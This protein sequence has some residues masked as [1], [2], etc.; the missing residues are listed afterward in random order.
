MPERPPDLL[1]AVD[2]RPPL[3]KLV[4]LGLQHAAL[5][6]IYLVFLVI[7]AQAAG[8]GSQMTVTVLSLGML[9]LA[10]GAV[11]QASLIGSGYLAVPVFSAIYLGPSIVAAKAGGLGL[12]F[13]MTIFAGAFEVALSRA[14]PWLRQLFPPAVSGFIVLVVGISIG[15]VGIRHVVELGDADPG[16]YLSHLAVAGLTGG[17][18][19]ALAVWGTG[20]LRLL[21]SMV[22]LVAGFVVALALG[23]VPKD[24]L[25]AIAAAPIVAVPVPGQAG[26]SFTLA[27]A[28]AFAAAALAATLRTI[29]VVTICQKLNDADWKRPDLPNIE[30]GVLADGLG[31]S[32]GGLV[33]GMGMCTASSLVGV[34]RAVRATS[35]RIAY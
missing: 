10:G 2:E 7:V 4:G 15:L 26:L 9:A 11:L 31:C 27:L 23:L 16:G 28:P 12:V 14:L 17:I 32:L 18:S 5:V 21:G 34:S 19:I 8:V 3:L 13:G 20:P 24:A 35:R 25:Q 1:Y 29:G 33:G 22:G 6:S 30:R